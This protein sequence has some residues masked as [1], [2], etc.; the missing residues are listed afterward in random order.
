LLG[1]VLG[2]GSFG[3]VFLAQQ[4][5]LDLRRVAL[6][7]TACPG[8]E[9]QTLARLEH[10]HIVQLL[11]NK[12]VRFKG[13]DLRLLCM[14]YEPGATLEQVIQA[15]R[16]RD[17]GEWNGR[18]ILEIIDR[19]STHP[20]PLH[21]A[22]L[23]DRQ[24][25]GEADWV[26]AVCWIGAR[27]AEA[28]DYAHAQGPIHRDVKPANILM[29]GYGRPMLTDFNLSSNRHRRADSGPEIF[30]GT[31]PFMA[32]EHL[33]AFSRQQ[34]AAAEAVDRRSDLY[35]LGVVLFEMLTGRLPFEQAMPAPVTL[36]AVRAMAT[37]RRAGAPSPRD[38]HPDVP[39][40]LA[41]V[42]RRCL[43]PPP[44]N[45]Y[46]TGAELAQALEDCHAIRAV[47]RNLPPAGFL[48]RPASR[49]P[50]LWL[51][52]FI[53]L[54]HVLGSLVNIAYNKTQIIDGLEIAAR[55]EAFFR[56]VLAYNAVVYP[57]CLVAM[58]WLIAPVFRTWRAL[59]RSEAVDNTQVA[60]GRRKALRWSRWVVGLSCAGWL[61]GAILFPLAIS[62]MAGPIH[63]EVF[64]HFLVSFTV[65]GLIA[66]TYAYFG[67][68]FMVLR[69]LYPQLWFDPQGFR[70]GVVADFR[71]RKPRLWV[72]QLLAGVIPLAGAIMILAGGAHLSG[73][74]MFRLLATALILLGM[75]GFGLAILANNF[76]SQ[77]LAALIGRGA[78]PIG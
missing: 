32:P 2:K 37:A 42:V 72:F 18:A 9:A 46:Q 21:P 60:A 50:F 54:P 70:E 55:Q 76:L 78:G 75:A 53:L 24:L 20:V 47:E 4:L 45:R 66:L 58:G 11:S 71:L 6:K 41:Q 65:S 26:Q 14:R 40:V 10:D 38:E 68:Q 17:R 7:I 39:E 57:A 49:R 69:F 62:F 36:E 30:G 1:K 61:P 77:T 15:L 43:A 73:D 5:S 56:L 44:D 63:R 12:V 34:A 8:G 51:S 52:S 28:L 31:L 64:G 67:V 13:Q 19:L 22:A 59:R 74:A 3:T 27:L 33:D 35:S 48:G 16:Q 23:R 25:L 29:N